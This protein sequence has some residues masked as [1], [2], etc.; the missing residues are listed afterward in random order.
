[1][2]RNP[3]AHDQIAFCVF[4]SFL[5][6]VQTGMLA[7]YMR[8]MRNNNLEIRLRAPLVAR[9]YGY[10]SYKG[11]SIGHFQVTQGFFFQSKAK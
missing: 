6:E 11:P 1:M 2:I 10:T 4:H 8:R 9:N 5:V 7:K 3:K